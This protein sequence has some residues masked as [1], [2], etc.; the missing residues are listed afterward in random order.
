MAPKANALGAE[1]A[2]FEIYLHGK[3]NHIDL[4]EF[5]L[6]VIEYHK[7]SKGHPCFFGDKIGMQIPY[8]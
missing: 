5:L 1:R 3:N 7:S 8:Y 2:V 6:S 4:L